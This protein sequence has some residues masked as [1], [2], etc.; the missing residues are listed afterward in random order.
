MEEQAL[1]ELDEMITAI[2]TTIFV[3]RSKDVL[4]TIRLRCLFHLGAWMKTDPE[5]STLNRIIFFHS[6]NLRWIEDD[7]LK[8]IG[9]MASDRSHPVRLEAIEVL[10]ELLEVDFTPFLASLTSWS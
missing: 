10:T 8:Y 9:W 4:D 3:S 5:R 2:F 1:R 6:R 7:Y